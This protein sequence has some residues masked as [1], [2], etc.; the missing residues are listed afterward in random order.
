MKNMGEK[1]GIDFLKCFVCILTKVP[2]ENILKKHW[3]YVFD[4]VKQMRSTLVSAIT[5]GYL[6]GGLILI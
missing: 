3:N 1:Y 6:F 2:L 5:L 4:V